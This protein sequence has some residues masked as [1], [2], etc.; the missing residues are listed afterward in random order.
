MTFL[1][2]GAASSRDIY[3]PPLVTPRPVPSILSLEMRLLSFRPLDAC[4]EP[5]E[6][7]SQ[8]HVR[9]CKSISHA[10][11][12]FSFFS[13]LN[14]ETRHG[15]SMMV[16]EGI[17]TVIPGHVLSESEGAARNLKII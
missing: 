16:S 17:S 12:G 11:G 8:I 10:R 9:Y 6:G 15:V 14:V 1:I 13:F 2:V 3:V 4:P 7:G 5:V